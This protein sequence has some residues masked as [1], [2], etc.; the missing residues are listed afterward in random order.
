MRHFLLCLLLTGGP[1]LAQAT[2]PTAYFQ[3]T[4][5][6]TRADPSGDPS[7]LPKTPTRPLPLVAVTKVR[8]TVCAPAGQTLSGTGTVRLWLYD[9]ALALWGYNPARNLVV[10][11][12]GA[13]CQPFDLWVG[14]RRGWLL[15]AAA[16]VGVSSGSTVTVRVDVDSN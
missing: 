14:V 12:S 10:N 11:V 8:V 6:T 16:G 3:E 2:P 15:P 5:S 1:A 13:A 7:A 4:Q 9:P